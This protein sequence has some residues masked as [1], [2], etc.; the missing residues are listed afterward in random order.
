MFLLLTLGM[1]LY[2]RTY[3]L[4]YCTNGFPL[5]LILAQLTNQLAPY[6][7]YI[8]I[9]I[10]KDDWKKNSDTEINIYTSRQSLPFVSMKPA[11][12]STTT[13]GYPQKHFSDLQTNRPLPFTNKHTPKA[14][15]DANRKVKYK[16]PKIDIDFG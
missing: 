8:S 11:K 9:Q 15:A 3:W 12:T 2:T 5:Q 13:N 14:H 6:L 10:F 1:Y 4:F 16:G 7:H